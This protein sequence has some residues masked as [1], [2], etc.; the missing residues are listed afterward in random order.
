MAEAIVALNIAMPILSTVFVGARIL[1]RRKTSQA[2]GSDDWT[3]LVT[4]VIYS[5]LVSHTHWVVLLI[6]FV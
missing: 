6:R 5:T 2:L 3:M 4:L 1:T